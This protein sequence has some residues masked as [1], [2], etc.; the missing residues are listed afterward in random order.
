[1]ARPKEYR[2]KVDA[3]TLLLRMPPYLTW[4]AQTIK[5]TAAWAMDKGGGQ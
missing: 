4:N 5:P 2:R 1:M 3:V